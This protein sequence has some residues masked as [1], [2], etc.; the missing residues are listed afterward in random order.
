MSCVWIPL[1]GDTKHPDV[2]NGWQ[3]PD[4]T[5]VAPEGRVGLRLDDYIV[6]DCDDEE[7]RDRWLRHIQQPLLHTWVR[8]TPNGWHFFY[9]RNYT[10]LS[11]RFGPWPPKIDIKGG[12]G[13]YVVFQSDGYYNLNLS[14][15]AIVFDPAWAPKEE[16][17]R[18]VDEWHECPDGI[19][20]NMMISLAGTMRRWGMDEDT[21]LSILVDINTATMTINPMPLRSLRRI[22]R[23]AA[24]YVPEEAKQAVCPHCGGEVELR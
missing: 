10:N 22:A 20:D 14:D 21:I 17:V 3:L 15:L 13:H 7:A 11:V 19:G 8:K 16:V 18:V 12:L 5:G 23:Q 2:L 24:K 6:I 1:K 4:Y 9:K